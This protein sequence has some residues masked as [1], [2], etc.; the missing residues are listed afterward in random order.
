GSTIIFFF[1]RMIHEKG[2]ADKEKAVYR[3][4]VRQN[5]AS[6]VMGVLT[7]MEENG[8][9]FGTEELRVRYSSQL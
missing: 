9:E 3:E 2:F 1:S 6:A 5:V 8:V 7:E 4:V